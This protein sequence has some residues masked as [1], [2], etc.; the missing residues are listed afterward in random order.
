VKAQ[1]K[2][3]QDKLITKLQTYSERDVGTSTAVV[4]AGYVD[5]SRS[6]ED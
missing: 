2:Q 6:V 1:T 5:F 4:E 3:E